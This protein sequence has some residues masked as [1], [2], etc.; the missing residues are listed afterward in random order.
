MPN[1]AKGYSL[2]AIESTFGGIQ[3]LLSDTAVSSLPASLTTSTPLTAANTGMHLMFV[4]YGHTTTGTI[5]SAGTAP[6]SVAAVTSTSTTLAVCALGDSPYAFYITPEVYGAVNASGITVSGLT[7]GRVAIYG[8][9]AATRLIPGE[10][11]IME[12]ARIT[13]SFNSVAPSRR[14]TCRRCRS[15]MSRSLR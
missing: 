9:Q 3:L 13:T 10:I 5:S 4:V 7:N 12:S 15:P 8:I 1:A 6:N 2:A 11:K 14:A